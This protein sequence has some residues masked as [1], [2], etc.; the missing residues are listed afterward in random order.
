MATTQKQ[1]RDAKVTP[2]GPKGDNPA[3]AGPGQTKVNSSTPEN[4]DGEIDP[5]APGETGTTPGSTRVP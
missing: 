4:K 5:T 3:T 2:S 1:E